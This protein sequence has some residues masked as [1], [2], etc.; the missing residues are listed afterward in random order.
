[1]TTPLNN[2]VLKGFDILRLFSSAR[3]ELGAARLMAEL[4]MNA[5]TAHRFLTTLEAAGAVMTVSRGRY[6]LGQLTADLGRIAAE[7]NPL[8][9]HIQPVL[10]DLAETLGESVMACRPSP[11]APVCI[12]V[13]TG[14]R[15]FAMGFRAGTLLGLTT[16]AQGKL[17]LAHMSA[18]E[19]RRATENQALPS[20]PEAELRQILAQGYA[21]NQG[22]AEPDVGAIAVPVLAN[23]GFALSLSAFGP[24]GRIDTGFRQ[25][26]LPKLRT[27][28]DDLAARLQT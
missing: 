3:P 26:A 7:T 25:K 15:P 10:D 20:P 14:S 28:A 4:D 2:S 1:M 9:A 16:S 13:A 27:A 21:L 12:A 22:S 6:R 23:G 17:L 18:P 24:L 11:A 19:R 5:A 8:T